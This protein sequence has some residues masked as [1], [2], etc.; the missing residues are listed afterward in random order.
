MLQFDLTTF[1]SLLEA[2][3]ETGRRLYG[4]AWRGIEAFARQANDPKSTQDKRAS[5][6]AELKRLAQ[7]ETP[8]NAMLVD[9]AGQQAWDEASAA[10]QL[11]RQERD[12]VRA[13][14]QE[15]P[16]ITDSSVKDHEAY[17]RR[18]RVECELKGAFARGEL[19]LLVAPHTLA[20]W[21]SWS[22]YKGFRLYFGLSMARLPAEASSQRRGPAFVE[23]AALDNWLERF[24][25]PDIGP[26]DLTPEAQLRKWLVEQTNQYAPK[27]KKKDQYLAEAQATIDGVTK[28]MFEHVWT[29]T[30]PQS[31]KK[32]GPA[33][34]KAKG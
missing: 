22:A 26:A 1:Y 13:R 29:N 4:E 21:R 9:G 27:E 11:I 16:D 20:D 24:G 31:W 15:I 33:G 7:E 17:Q 32:A 19:P 10:L 30:V 28:R 34:P 8:H 5:L 14:L 12:A 2:F 25:V 6:L 18:C 3:D 23:R